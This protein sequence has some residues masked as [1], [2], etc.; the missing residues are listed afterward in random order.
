MKETEILIIGAGASGLMAASELSKNGKQVT[1]VEAKDRIGGRIKTYQQKEFSF[2]AEGGAEFIHGDLPITKSLIKDAC[3]TLISSE[4]ELW[5]VRE[6]KFKQDNEFI[7]DWNKLIEKLK[8][9][10][11]DLPIA[12]FLTIN[13]PKEKYPNLHQAI[14]A[15]IEGYDAADP[16][17]ASTI[18][19]RD[20][21]ISE[22]EAPQYR[23]KEGYGA[24]MKYLETVCKKNGV[25]IKLNFSVKSVKL[26]DNKAEIICTTGDT[27]IAKIV[28][29][30]V[31]LPALSTIE[32]TPSI[33]EKLDASSKIGFGNVIKF[34][35]EFKNR[36]W[37]QTQSVDLTKAGFF[38]SNQTVP[39]WWTQYPN[40]APLLTGWL[41]GPK[42]GRYIDTSSEE[43]LDIAIDSLSKIFN[44][45][46]ENIKKEIINWK[47]INWGADSYIQGAYAYATPE[48]PAAKSELLKPTNDILYFSG[49]ALYNGKEMGTVE[50]ALA[51]GCQT[52]KDILDKVS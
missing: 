9:V 17:R 15:F 11:E 35:F 26:I 31:P 28:V 22:N 29:I 12:D 27:Y 39:T 16:T 43:L 5:N 46:Q 21:W 23:L 51:A 34:L 10:K 19:L 33:K 18:A 44:F 45:E 47:V 14:Y 1:V 48:T 50:A 24:L 37:L 41:A 6:G 42:A 52:A 36:W 25:T 49:E 30:T 38:F 7:P 3:L 32:F 2:I 40:P 20:E 8:L 13:F 4:G